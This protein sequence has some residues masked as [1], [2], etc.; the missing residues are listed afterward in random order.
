MPCC[1]KSISRQSAI[2][3][4]CY[5]RTFSSFLGMLLAAYEHKVFVQGVIWGINSFDQWGLELRKQLAMHRTRA[6]FT[7][8][9]RA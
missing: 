3:Y 7:R 8:T 1:H 4:D 5:R 9:T 2:Q 6:G